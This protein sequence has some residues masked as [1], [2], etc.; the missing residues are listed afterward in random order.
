[1]QQIPRERTLYLDLW[2]WSQLAKSTEL[3]MQFIDRASKTC[4]IMY[5]IS[6]MME[7][8]TIR[9]P[10]QVSAIREVM[11]S[12]DFGFIESDPNVVIGLERQYEIEVGSGVFAERHPAADHAVLNHLIKKKYPDTDLKMSELFTELL[13]EFPDRYHEQ[14]SHFAKTMNELVRKVR[15]SEAYLVKAKQ[16]RRRKRPERSGP[17]YTEDILQRFLDYVVTSESLRMTRNDWM[18]MLHLIVPL[19]YLSSVLTDGRWVHFVRSELQLS[20]FNIAQVF[21]PREVDVFLAEI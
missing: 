6:T 3:R 13:E 20:S 14:A 8:A 10:Q 11:D 19:S 15:N 7:L 17:P 12:V 1:M 2:F 4:T 18:D 9:H 5:S 16:R 21:G